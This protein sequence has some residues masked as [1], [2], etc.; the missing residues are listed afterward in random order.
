MGKLVITEVECKFIDLVSE[1][2]YAD[3]C[4]VTMDANFQDD[5]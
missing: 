2:I 4:N 1:K 5:L 3:N